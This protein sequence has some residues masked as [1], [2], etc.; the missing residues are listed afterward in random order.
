MTV[1]RS[2]ASHA[3]VV[4][5][6]VHDFTQQVIA[7]Q[8]RLEAR[9]REIV[10]NALSA[11]RDDQRIVLD[12]PGGIAV[13]VLAN[14]EG[15]LHFAWRAAAERDLDFSVGLAHGPVRIA[16]GPLHVVYG[17]ALLTAEAV[18]RAT[19][20]GNVSAAREFRDA[21]ARANPGMRR[22]LT[23]IGSAVDAHDRAHEMFR[24]DRGSVDSRQRTF[25]AIAGVMAAIVLA[26][27]IGIRANRP[28]PPPPP[29]APEPTP[30]ALTFDIK[31]EGEVYIDGVLK[32]MSPPLK[33]IQ[34]PPGKHVVEVRSGTMKPMSVDLAVGSGE[35]FAVQHT[36][37]APPPPPPPPK[38]AA[39][40]AVKPRPG[41]PQQQPHKQQAESQEKSVWDRVVDWFHGR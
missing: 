1:A 14:P 28:P 9:L 18:A 39:K 3:S 35:E 21:I 31:P 25:Y 40:P 8:A 22:L 41:R 16:P 19:E 38:A 4:F 5:L 2:T 13:V 24:A 33:R 26:I 11:L 32:G 29:P 6:K 7:E 20:G 15:A 12:A 23:R 34:L 27:G 30:G 36:F 10:Q 17:D 37:V